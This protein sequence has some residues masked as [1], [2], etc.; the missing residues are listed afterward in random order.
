VASVAA[1][2]P[3]AA[4]QGFVTYWM[5]APAWEA[6]GEERR[7]AVAGT[8]AKVV[9]EWSGAFAPTTRLADYAAFPA[10]TL[11]IRAADTTLAARRITNLIRARLGAHDFVEVARGGHMSPVTN[12]E[13]VNSAIAGF[14]A[15]G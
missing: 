9:A 10:P 14:L 2:D 8:M 11:L 13:P 7:R 5:G 15:G 4:A 6:M 1:G 12:P 3:L